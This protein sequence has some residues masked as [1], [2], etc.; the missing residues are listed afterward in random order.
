MTKLLISSFPDAVPGKKLHVSC[1]NKA[2]KA[3]AKPTDTGS[4]GISSE[5]S[6]TSESDL[7]IAGSDWK[8]AETSG[9]TSKEMVS[10]VL[11]ILGE[12]HMNMHGKA[13]HQRLPLV[14]QKLSTAPQNLNESFSQVAKTPKLN[15]LFEDK[16]C[17]SSDAVAAQDLNQLM[18]ELKSKFQTTMSHSDQVQILTCKPA[19]WIIEK[20]AHFFQCTFHTV[21]QALAVKA[22]DGVL[23]KPT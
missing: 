16:P 17:T 22:K 20:T 10:T 4:G 12:S 9:N 2:N 21:Q 6:V 1:W 7:S 8:H 5:S 11:Q 14:K 3:A 15:I 23:A 18:N 19:L 13:M